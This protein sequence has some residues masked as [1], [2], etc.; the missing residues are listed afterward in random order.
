M[1]VLRPRASS[2]Y[3]PPVSCLCAVSAPA[4]W[5]YTLIMF[6]CGFRLQYYEVITKLLDGL[7]LKAQVSNILLQVASDSESMQFPLKVITLEF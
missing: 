7:S 4:V 5:Q 6:H 2:S 1:W 3:C